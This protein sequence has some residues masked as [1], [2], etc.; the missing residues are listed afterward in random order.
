MADDWQPTPPEYKP[1]ENISP[2][3][4]PQPEEFKGLPVRAGGDRVFLLKGGKKFW[5]MNAEAFARLG[6]KF[7]DE[8][9]IDEATLSV[10]AEGEPLK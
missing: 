8:A 4:A 3:P 6:F 10:I 2:P 5:I 1:P 7:G 9:R